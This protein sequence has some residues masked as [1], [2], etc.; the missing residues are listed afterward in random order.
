MAY[1]IEIKS[2]LG[3]PEEAQR[4]RDAMVEV[5]PDTELIDENAQLNH[6]FT[7]GDIRALIDAVSPLLT[8]EQLERLQDIASRGR[9]FSVR[10]REVNGTVY[11][12]VKASVD[13]TTSEN[14]I[15]RIEFQEPVDRTLDEL[16]NMI[17][18][19]GY[20]YQAKW[21]RQRE[22]YSCSGATVCL[23]KNAGYGYLAEFE[24]VVEREDEA[25]Q[26][27]GQLYQLMEQL[28]V[29]ELSQER[30]QRMF[31][32]YNQH[33]PEYYGTDKIFTVK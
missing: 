6:Y 32:Y 18:D 33:W 20:E 24:R 23:D 16:D 13:D 14:G 31:E 29:E 3:T 8:G 2:L 27:K 30:L 5:D 10:T 26:A 1:E 4:V 11:V 15:S 22:E 7:G 12:V 21:S 25:D 28:G 19:A 9:E 17:L